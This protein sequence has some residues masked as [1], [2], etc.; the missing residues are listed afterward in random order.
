M[1]LLKYFHPI[2]G[3]HSN[4]ETLPSPAGTLSPNFSHAREHFPLHRRPNLFIDMVPS[5][6]RLYREPVS[7][8]HVE[9]KITWKLRSRLSHVQKISNCVV[10]GFVPAV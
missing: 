4:D 10:L 7:F 5:N 2:N 9:T 3:K 1:S 6:H 8:H